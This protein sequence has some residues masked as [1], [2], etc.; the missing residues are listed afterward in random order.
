MTASSTFGYAKTDEGI[1]LGYRADGDGPIDIVSQSD[2]P[3]NIDLEWED[4]FLG[5][6]LRELRS[7]SRVI[8]HDPRGIGLSS[9]NVDLPTLETRVSEPHDR[10][11]HDRGPPAGAH[12]L[13][14]FDDPP[15]GV[16][17]P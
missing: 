15:P 17:H 9:R 11:E 16:D 13:C 12:G 7:F 6:W 5:S 10:P 8:T 4:P 3:G 1:Y 2:W 14:W